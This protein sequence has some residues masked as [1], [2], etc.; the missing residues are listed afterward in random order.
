MGCVGTRRIE[1]GD[2][3]EVHPIVLRRSDGAFGPVAVPLHGPHA[4]VYAKSLH[5]TLEYPP[6]IIISA[7]FTRSDAG[8]A[9]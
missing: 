9:R 7:P 2:L 6:S 3:N 4:G 5:Q 8:E 1:E